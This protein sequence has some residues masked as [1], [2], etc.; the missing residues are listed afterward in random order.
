MPGTVC[1]VAI[2]G[3]FVAVSDPLV[4]IRK[5]FVAISPDLVAIGAILVA[6][7]RIPSTFRNPT[8][9]ESP[10]VSGIPSAF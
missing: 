5:D 8:K 7:H 4:A 9:K 6:I 10:L 3:S 1:L 2:G